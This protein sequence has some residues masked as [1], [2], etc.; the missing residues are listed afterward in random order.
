[1]DAYGLALLATTRLSLAPI[2][3]VLTLLSNAAPLLPTHLLQL[4]VPSITVKTALLLQG[5]LGLVNFAIM[6]CL[7]A[8]PTGVRTPRSSV[9]DALAMSNVVLVEDAIRAYV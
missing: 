7:R 5:V 4:T 8:R 9:V 6:L 1:M 3:D 2:P